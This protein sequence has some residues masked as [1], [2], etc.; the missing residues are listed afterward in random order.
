MGLVVPTAS[1]ADDPSSP[2]VLP[3]APPAS[4]TSPADGGDGQPAHRR[5][6]RP[7]YVLSE[8][9]ERLSLTADQQKKVGAIIDDGAAQAKALRGDGSLSRDEKRQKMGA[10]MKATHDQIRAALTPDQQKQFDALPQRGGGSRPPSS[11]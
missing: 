1:R 5:H 6:M 4:Q 11:N 8:L 7:A 9:T 3:A 10:V 2:P